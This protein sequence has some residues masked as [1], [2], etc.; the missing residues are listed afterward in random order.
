MVNTKNSPLVSVVIPVFNGASYLRQA[1][2]SIL[3]STYQNIEVLL[4]DDGSSDKSKHLCLSLQKKYPKVRFY[5]FPENR[6]QG[7]AL[8]HAIR[9]A[10]GKY[11]CR[12]NQDDTMLP[13]RIST[14]VEYLTQHP[15]VVA[16]GSAIVLFD[17]FGHQQIVNFSET[18]TAIKKIW[19]ILS[20]FA[21]PSVMFNKKVALAVGGHDQAFWPANDVHLWVRMG[22]VGQLANIKEPLVH[23]FYH[24]KAASVKHF[25]KVT[26]T[27]YKLHLWMDK[28]IAPAPW[29]VKLFWLGQYLSGKIL[30][31]NFN[32]AFYRLIKRFIY[33]LNTIATV[34]KVTNQP[35]MANISGQ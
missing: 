17:E 20:P 19:H 14:Q 13:H 35:I 30:S 7:V 18:D 26:D 23:V 5:S 25:G 16:L 24:S 2:S 15:E 8:N 34:A 27:T 11:I 31:P 33:R 28:N 29:Y 9:M 4:V 12:L 21:D 10:R 6:G 1:V 32:W 3:K 22:Q